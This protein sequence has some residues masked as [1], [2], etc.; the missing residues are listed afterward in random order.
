[1][2]AKRAENWKDPNRDFGVSFGEAMLEALDLHNK[3]TGRVAL[4]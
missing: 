2:F 3:F 4:L 1:M